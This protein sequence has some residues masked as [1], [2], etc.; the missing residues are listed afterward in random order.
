[1]VTDVKMKLILNQERINCHFYEEKA[2]MIVDSPKLVWTMK[3]NLN[4]EH[5][6]EYADK[7]KME[8][9]RNFFSMIWK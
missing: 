3:T 7:E 9:V 5:L 8:W 2:R 6:N 1:M 4:D